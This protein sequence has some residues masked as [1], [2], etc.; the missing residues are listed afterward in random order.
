MP[1]MIVLDRNL[2]IVETTGAASWWLEESSNTTPTL[3]WELPDPVYAV[4][5]RLR[6]N[7]CVANP[8]RPPRV[9]L[10]IK[11]GTWIVI[12]ATPVTSE[13]LDGKVGVIFEAGR[14]SVLA[15]LLS[16]AYR[17]TRRETELTRLIVDGCSTAQIAEHMHVLPNTVQ[18]H[19]QAVYLKLGVRSRVELVA[20]IHSRLDS[21][22]TW[23]TSAVGEPAPAASR[24][25]AARATGGPLSRPVG[26][27]DP[28]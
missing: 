28:S 19:T 27:I 23:V 17:L 25:V 3:G 18:D 1:A 7:N 6:G 26:D 10:Q 11:G 4:I 20:R 15:P 22:G 24:R 13:G 14:P 12:S 8:G 5:S 16:Q 21:G 9:R 2:H